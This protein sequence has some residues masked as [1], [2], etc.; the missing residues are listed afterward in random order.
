MTLQDALP[1]QESQFSLASIGAGTRIRLHN[2]F[3]GS[4][5][6]GVPLIGQTESKMWDLLL[7]FRV[8]AEF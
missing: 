2:H 7:T 5:D 4:L 1:E 3:N 8:W 6:L